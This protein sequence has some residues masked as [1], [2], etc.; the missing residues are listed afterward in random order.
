VRNYLSRK[1]LTLQLFPRRTRRAPVSVA[2]KFRI[3][4]E[5][6]F[7]EGF[8]EKSPCCADILI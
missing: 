1:Q 6:F 4:A 8:I 3:A 5:R 2:R 7:A